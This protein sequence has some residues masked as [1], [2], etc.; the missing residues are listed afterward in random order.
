M[1]N[2][3]LNSVNIVVVDYDVNYFVDD[4]FYRYLNKDTMLYLLY[5]MNSI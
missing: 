2:E 3:E 5:E 4:D 1:D